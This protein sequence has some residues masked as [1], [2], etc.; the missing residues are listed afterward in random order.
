MRS[1]EKQWYRFP[2]GIIKIKS[3]LVAFATWELPGFDDPATAEACALNLA[4]RLAVDCCFMEV[5]FKCDNS[6]VISCIKS[7][8][9][10]PRSYLGNVV[11][12]IHCNMV[13]F[14]DCRFG[15][16]GKRFTFATLL[17][18]HAPYEFSFLLFRYLSSSGHYKNEKF[19]EKTS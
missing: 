17:V 14:R 12:S 4:V 11:W 16:I 18:S 8:N 19:G 10:M 2:E 5:I 6:C 13:H 9:V 15:Y 7:Q 1:S 3:H